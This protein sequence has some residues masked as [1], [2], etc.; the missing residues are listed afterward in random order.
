MVDWPKTAL[1]CSTASVTTSTCKK[2][3]VV[4]VSLVGKEEKVYGKP[5]N[6]KHGALIRAMAFPCLL[7]GW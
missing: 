1:K 5:E 7:P 2:R 6:F 4:D 3:S